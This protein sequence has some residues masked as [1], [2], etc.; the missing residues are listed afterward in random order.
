MLGFLGRNISFPVK[1]IHRLVLFFYLKKSDKIFLFNATIGLRSN[2][3]FNS[4]ATLQLEFV[5]VLVFTLLILA[6]LLSLYKGK[7]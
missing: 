1:L 4:A 5:R 7:T 3:N 6:S 2:Y